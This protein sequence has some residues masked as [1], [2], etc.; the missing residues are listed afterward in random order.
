MSLLRMVSMGT[1]SSRENYWG[2]IAH[3]RAHPDVRSSL[4]M[5]KGRLGRTRRLRFRGRKI[6]EEVIFGA[7]VMW[8]DDQ[9]V[10][11]LE[12]LL[13]PYVVRLER[14]AEEA[15]ANAFGTPGGRVE[16][17]SETVVNHP[18]TGRGSIG[19]GLEPE[20]DGKAG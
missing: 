14:M 16:G 4:A 18:R 1:K 20:G 2:E 13:K 15:Q 7:L 17:V 9:P 12:D 6:S 19:L 10:E 5:I 3:I 11:A 8:A